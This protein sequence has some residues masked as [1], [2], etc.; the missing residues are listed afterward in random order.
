MATAADTTWKLPVTSDRTTSLSLIATS[1]LHGSSVA[2][3]AWTAVPHSNGLHTPADGS[4]SAF[5]PPADVAN[6]ASIAAGLQQYDPNASTARVS[7]VD[8]SAASS[9]SDRCGLIK[10]PAQKRARSPS[11][12]AQHRKFPSSSSSSTNASQSH[13]QRAAA[14][15]SP[16]DDQSLTRRQL[17]TSPGVDS[18][19]PLQ[20]D[21]L[22]DRPLRHHEYLP[23]SAADGSKGFDLLSAWQDVSASSS[24][25]SS[26]V[27]A[28][29]Q[30]LQ[31]SSVLPPGVA[32]ASRY[33]GG[34]PFLNPPSTTSSSS[35]SVS[36]AAGSFYYP[37]PSPYLML[38]GAAPPALAYPQQTVPPALPHLADPAAWMMS[39]MVGGATAEP[40]TAAASKV[41]AEHLHQDVPN[42]FRRTRPPTSASAAFDFPWM[43]GGGIQS[44]SGGAAAHQFLAAP[45]SSFTYPACDL[46][47]GGDHAAAAAA[48]QSLSQY[49]G[50]M[51]GLQGGADPASL[52][53]MIYGRQPS[54]AY[55]D[56]AAM[57]GIGAAAASRLLHDGTVHPA[58]SYLGG[59]YPPSLF[60]SPY[61]G[62]PSR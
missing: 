25:V 60:H 9:S 40:P 42:Q 26:V 18:R 33:L 2:N 13:G 5:R 12:E 23:P 1:K 8:D 4:A 55:S 34:L 30:A 61:L 14:E 45:K 10:K 52:D 54:A 48:K 57:S 31:S 36:A 21:E 17:F 29:G 46:Y 62:I 16:R 56:L 58:A 49:V 53:A 28:G 22:S 59:I 37:A 15:S 19:R 27:G 44:S 50:L 3:D 39:S 51:R 41:L 43:R 38:P 24:A 32:A 47:D 35:S 7:N 6:T 20:R 11:T